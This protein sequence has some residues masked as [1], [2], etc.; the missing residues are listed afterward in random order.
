M[1]GEKPE[2]AHQQNNQNNPRS[3]IACRPEN[4]PLIQIRRIRGAGSK[5]GRQGACTAL[6]LYSKT[7]LAKFVALRLQPLPQLHHLGVQRRQISRVFEHIIGARRLFRIRN[8]VLPAAP[9]IG[10][11]ASPCPPPGSRAA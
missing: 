1:R 5:S 11:A 7:R 2:S 3:L 10:R 9:R 8:L 4:L 6:P